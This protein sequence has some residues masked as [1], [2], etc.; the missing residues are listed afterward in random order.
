ML[1]PECRLKIKEFCSAGCQ[2]LF[3]P[4]CVSFEDFS[5]L[6]TRFVYHFFG[7]RC[8]ISVLHRKR[9]A[10][11]VRLGPLP[12]GQVQRGKARKGLEPQKM[13]R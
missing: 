10:T 8:E 13:E 4:T 9:P 2:L 3:P 11:M 7:P 6:I 1:A 5:K 12:V